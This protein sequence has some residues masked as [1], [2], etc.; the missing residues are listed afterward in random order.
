[1]QFSL[2]DIH[3]A[4]AKLKRAVYYEKNDL[5]LRRRLANF[6]L[7]VQASDAFEKILNVINSDDPTQQ[8]DFE[9]WLGSVSFRL[10][11]KA[12][13]KSQCQN[14]ESGRFISNKTSFDI[15]SIRKVNYFFDGPIELHVIS[16]LWIMREGYLLDLSLGPECYGA[17][18]EPQIGKKEDTS[19]QLY[20]RY[21]ELYKEWRD[22]GIK[23]ATHMLADEQTSVCILGLDIQEYYYHINLDIAELVA[24]VTVAQTVI[25]A[26]VNAGHSLIP[27]R[28]SGLLACLDLIHQRYHSAIVE[29]LGATHKQLPTH[30]VGLPIGLPSSAL[31]ANWYLKKFDKAI[32]HHLRPAFYGRY[33]DD[34]FLVVR[35]PDA[36]DA[37]A[38][39]QDFVADLLVKTGVLKAPDPT[40]KRY[41]LVSRSGLFLQEEKFILQHF[42]AS[43]SIAGLNK[44]QKRLERNGS[45]FMLLPLE[46][47]DSSLESVAYELLY[48]GSVNK[49]RSVKGVAE[50]RFELAKY[51]S[52]Q[53]TLHLL[54]DDAINPEVGKTVLQFFKGKNAIDF[55]DLW[56][57]VFTFFIA[58]KDV[59]SFRKFAKVLAAE[60][61]KVAYENNL[62]ITAL[63]QKNLYDHLSLSM[64]MARSLSD[65]C[66]NMADVA[67][68]LFR[69][70]NMLRHQF[71]RD[72]LLNYTD[73]EGDLTRPTRSGSA[74]L[75]AI[76]LAGS[77]RKLNF[78]ECMLLVAS[79]LLK[80]TSVHQTGEQQV[81]EQA[82]TIYEVA[83]RRSIV[84]VFWGRSKI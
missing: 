32:H 12:Q 10:T 20:K 19:H 23:K 28:P 58:A 80:G 45:D 76:K 47:A 69:D 26:E 15:L 60:I 44:F 17:R 77:P 2:N 79:G 81:F 22:C 25:Q 11:P 39:V 27:S 55:F 7:S 73:Y 54:T 14:S 4:Y 75:D 30:S 49:F 72:P 52:K 16:V 8:P 70:A 33:V 9:T 6:D 68:M 63:L 29:V 1:M 53:S 84:G 57:R 42:D 64:A 24:A 35:A 37:C 36:M 41:E 34:I 65:P 43:H 71:V 51:L 59:S 83:N 66:L 13:A 82:K 46:E 56:E 74:N 31:L 38:S 18:L 3:I 48:D 40:L 78:D 5:Q 62:G 67:S 61:K 21:H 50:N